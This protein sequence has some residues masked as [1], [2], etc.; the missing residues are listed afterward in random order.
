MYKF[1]LPESKK[2]KDLSRGMRM[3]YALAI[4]LSHGADILVLDEPASGPDA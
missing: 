1:G 3:K 2:I 4:A